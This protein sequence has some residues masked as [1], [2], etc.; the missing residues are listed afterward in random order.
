MSNRI[1]VF[2]Q[3]NFTKKLNLNTKKYFLKS[4]IISFLVNKSNYFCDEAPFFVYTPAYILQESS[5]PD[6]AVNP[7]P[8]YH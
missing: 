1:L 3:N 4:L 5:Y 8:S 2:K 6:G 7:C